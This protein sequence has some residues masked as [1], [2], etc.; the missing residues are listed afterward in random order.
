MDSLLAALLRE[1]LLDPSRKIASGE[2]VLVPVR[3]R[4]D[5]PAVAARLGARLVEADLAPREERHTP[6]ARVLAL[7]PPAIRP[8]APEKWEKLGDVLVLRLAE[9]A[10]PHARELAAA[11]AQAL[12]CKCVVRDPGGVAGELREMQGELLFGDDPVTTHVES[13]VRYR[14]DASRIMFS[15]GNML[16]RKRAARLQARG[17]VVV[18]MFAGIGYFT[19]PVAMRSGAAKVIALEKNPLSFRYLQENVRLNGVEGVVEPWLGDNRDY[20]REGIADRVLM[21]YFPG[22]AAFLPKAMRLLKPQGGI[23]HYHGTAHA[24]KWKDEMTRALLAAARQCG[25]VVA[26]QEARSVKSH[27]PGVVHAVLVARVS[28]A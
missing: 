28:R 26:V 23:I 9:E 5:L 14:L 2:E 22:T 19:L 17:E 8:L 24:D 4:E 18:D 13:G 7:L 16:E 12:A 21:G 20:P 11:Y 10:L 27:S 3:P 6:H 25:A 15:S 1:G